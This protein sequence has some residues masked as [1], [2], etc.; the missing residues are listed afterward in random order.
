M[1]GMDENL[2]HY[3]I[4]WNK[5]WLNSEVTVGILKSTESRGI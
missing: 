1:L 3:M 4:L 5:G 2:R